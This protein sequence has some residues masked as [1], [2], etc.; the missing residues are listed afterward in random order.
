MTKKKQTLAGVLAEARAEKGL[1]L[2]EAADKTKEAEESGIGR[3]VSYGSI[4][5]YERGAMPR[6]DTL[7]AL[8][9]A[10]DIDVSVLYEVS[11]GAA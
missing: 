8:A 11:A 1:S 7:A 2:R 4:A 10:Y 9:W 5:D 6:P 3:A